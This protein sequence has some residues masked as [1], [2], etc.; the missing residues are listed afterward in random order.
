VAGAVAAAFGGLTYAR[1]LDYW[2][3]EAL[4]RDT[5]QKRPA[6]ARARISYGVELL[7]A[8]RFPEAEAQLRVAVGLDAGAATKA[9]AHMYLGSAL[10]AQGRHV[11]G[12][13]HLERALALD[14]TLGEANGLLG[15]AYASQGRFAVAA[16]YL[17]LA[18]QASPDN[19]LLLRR[20]AWL[21]ATA[22]QDDAR[23]GVR[24]VEMAERA[25]QLTTGQDAIALEAL[26]AAYAEQD[27]F[28]EAVTILRRA[29]DVASAQGFH[30][31]VPQLRQDLAQCEAGRKLRERPR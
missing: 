22:P 9:Q 19:P 18:V 14:A 4:M 8:S 29:I 6:N 12:V 1:N 3:A 26:G 10:C 16:K 30:A 21:L 7:T 23:D 2:S 11:E 28:A 27:R 25:T 17:L 5:V 31:F 24:A 15:E 20:A 13:P